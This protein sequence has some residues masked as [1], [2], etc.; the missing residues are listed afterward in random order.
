MPG[1]PRRSPPNPDCVIDPNELRFK[2][3]RLVRRTV[4]TVTP[5]DAYRH[6]GFL[7]RRQFDAG[8]R[9]RDIWH[10]AGRAPKMTG[11]LELVGHGRTEMTDNQARAWDRLAKMLNPLIPH[12]RA[13]VH[14]VCCFEHGAEW[15]AANLGQPAHVGLIM[16]RNALD[17]LSRVGSGKRRKPQVH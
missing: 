12:H 7:T 17:A 1:S 9:L 16:L 8:D 3:H 6:A 4:V 10:R 13:R 14:D 2:R 5:L 11:D 15:A